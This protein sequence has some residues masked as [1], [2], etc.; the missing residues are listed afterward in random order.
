MIPALIAALLIALVHVYG[1]RL[2]FSPSIPRSH[3][4][5]LAGGT[6]VAF[7]FV[8]VLPELG[9]GQ[10]AIRD[11]GHWLTDVLSHH[12]Y[13]VALGGLLI[14]YGLERTVKIHD[15]ESD[16][17]EQGIQHHIFWIHIGAFAF[18]NAVIGVLLIQRDLAGTN[19]I[20]F[21]IA[22]M[23]HFVVN[24]HALRDRHQRAYHDVGRW[25]LALAVGA[26]WLAGLLI[27]LSDAMV[28][29]LFA[30]IA[31]GLV[32]NVL[33]EELPRERESR[34]WAFALGAVAYT[35]LLLLVE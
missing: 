17:D 14:Y 20:T 35:G 34:F 11:T 25:L 33:K 6:S 9:R 24:D 8:H 10:E 1:V 4:L 21:T 26:G 18:Y 30:F 7:V 32:L 5:S 2:T 13:L 29:V 27:S 15:L 31:G 19:L 23:L 3:W 28:S 16:L 22:T 12:V